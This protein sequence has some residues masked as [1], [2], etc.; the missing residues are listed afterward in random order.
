[1]IE[2]GNEKM[3]ERKQERYNSEEVKRA[4]A[5]QLYR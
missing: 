4:I 2:V 3:P 5:R 1:L